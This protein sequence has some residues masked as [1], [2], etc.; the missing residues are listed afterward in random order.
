MTR[1]RA[2]QIIESKLNRHTC[3]LCE[4]ILHTN[5]IPKLTWVERVILIHKV[6]KYKVK[7]HYEWTLS[8]T[9]DYLKLNY[10]T[11]QE[12]LKLYEGVIKFPNLAKIPTRKHAEMCLRRK[13]Y[14]SNYIDAKLIELGIIDK[15]IVY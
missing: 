12:S 14:E 11:V 8:K 13:G 1:I 5:F 9:A 10:F 15:P 2:K 6:H 4:E 3:F 7:A